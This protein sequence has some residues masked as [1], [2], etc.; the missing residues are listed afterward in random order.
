LLQPAQAPPAFAGTAL[1]ARP[2]VVNA[3]VAAAIASA[4]DLMRAL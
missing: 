3:I 4:R 1:I 2:T